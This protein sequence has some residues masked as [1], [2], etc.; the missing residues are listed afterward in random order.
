MKMT[1]QK[2]PRIAGVA[3]VLV[4]CLQLVACK[5]DSALAAASAAPEVGV[6]TIQPQKLQLVTELPGRTSPFL[7]AEVR[8]QVG[9]ILLKRSFKEGA[10]VKA[11]QSLYEIDPAPYKAVMSRAEAAFQSAQSLANRYEQLIQTRAISQQQFDD[12]RSQYLQTKAAM[13]TARID[14]N[15]TK[16]GAPISGRIGR[17]TVTQG[18]LVTANQ[19]TALAT[20]QQLNPIYVDIVQ[21]STSL[22][23]LREEL[24][25]GR[26]KSA[27]GG[28]AEVHLTLDDGRPYPHPGKLQFSEVSVDESTGAVTLRAVFPNPQGLLLP[29]MFVR[30]QLQEGVRDNALLVPQRGVTRDTQGNAVA[31]VVDAKNSVQQRSLVTERSVEGQWLVSSGIKPGDRVILDGLQRV[32]PGIEVKPVPASINEK[33]AVAMAASK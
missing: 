18:A 2:M 15:Y 33:Q 29:G 22:L 30:A 28:E 25:S 20:I 24:A 3:V 5:K 21:P 23:R 17:S 7:I 14:L 11:G 13:D 1:P 4:T 16:I 10:E 27:A 8:P 31:M 9:G 12:A 26:L 19:G 6:L 32:R